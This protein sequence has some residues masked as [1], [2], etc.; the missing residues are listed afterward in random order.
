MN[1]FAKL[2]KAFKIVKELLSDKTEED[3]QDLNLHVQAATQELG[4]VVSAA[5]ALGREAEELVNEV[6]I[7]S[8]LASAIFHRFQAQQSGPEE[9]RALY[10]AAMESLIDEGVRRLADE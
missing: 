10:P 9:G 2:G 3:M 6:I 1:I 7:I 8:T 4:D 5:K